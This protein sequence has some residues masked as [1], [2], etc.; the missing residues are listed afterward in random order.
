M[1]VKSSPR[2]LA[3]LWLISNNA[4]YTK[5]LAPWNWTEV[6]RIKPLI[7][8]FDNLRSIYFL[9]SNK[10]F[11]SLKIKNQ[12]KTYE[13]TWICWSLH[14]L[15]RR[16]LR[17]VLLD[18]WTPIQNQVRRKFTNKAFC[19]TSK[20]KLKFKMK[21]KRFILAFKKVKIQRYV[22]ILKWIRIHKEL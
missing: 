15:I 11:T 9:K 14:P 4:A 7:R 20:T 6:K 12:I 17:W 10:I 1:S 21:G 22:P 2:K 3:I 18:S 19:K 16:F 5:V 8:K 13:G